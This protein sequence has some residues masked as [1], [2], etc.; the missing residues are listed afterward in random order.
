MASY[1]G[2]E[3]SFISNSE[4]E[5]KTHSKRT[6]ESCSPESLPASF[7]Y[8]EA[9]QGYDANIVLLGE[10]PFLAMRAP[11][12]RTQKEFF[13]ILSR[14]GVTDLVRLTPL[15]EGGV[16][17]TVPYWEGKININPQTYR[18]T[19]VIE[20]REMNY[21]RPTSGRISMG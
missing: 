7:V 10:K 3:K 16:E 18:P 14:Y 6:T 12:N 5:S 4:K 9:C 8:N 15:Y 19:V 17:R 2:S 13:D 11:T 21:V 20:G 1:A